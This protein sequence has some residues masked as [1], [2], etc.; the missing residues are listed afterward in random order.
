[1]FPPKSSTVPEGGGM[2][3]GPSARPRPRARPL[4]W[5]RPAPP[6]PARPASQH[7]G[8]RRRAAGIADAA[9]GGGGGA[10]V[11]G[12]GGPAERAGGRHGAAGAAQL[13]GRVGGAVLQLVLRTLRRLRPY[14]AGPGGGRQ[15]WG[16]GP[17][18]GLPRGHPL[19]GRAAGVSFSVGRGSW[20]GLRGHGGASAR[21]AP[22]ICCR[23][24][25]TAH[26]ASRWGGELWGAVG[27]SS[28]APGSMMRGSWAPKCHHLYDLCSPFRGCSGGTAGWWWV[29]RDAF[30]LSA[31]W[32]LHLLVALKKS[33]AQSTWILQCWRCCVCLVLERARPTEQEW[34]GREKRMARW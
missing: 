34:V 26:T 17:G 23:A 29:H 15:R 16:P 21:G 11:P 4:L 20:A 33:S 24:V 28:V 19:W 32:D 1:M 14:L 18:R 2:R 10:A 27:N 3:A 6:R 8:G 12:R 9:G 25:G 13:L 22:L 5:R 30:W 31:L 7:G